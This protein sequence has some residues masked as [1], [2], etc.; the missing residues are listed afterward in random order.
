MMKPKCSSFGM[1]TLA[2]VSSFWAIIATFVWLGLSSDTVMAQNGEPQ[3]TTEFRLEDCKFKTTGANPYFILKP[4]YQLVLE[5]EEDGAMVRLVVTVL[6]KTRR[7]F[8]PGIGKVNTRVVR[9]RHFEDNELVEVSRN[10]FAICEKTND[11][12]YFGE[13][14][15]IFN[16]DGTISNEGAWLAG[17]PDDD[18]LAEPGTFLLGARYFQELADGI[19]MDRA[20]HVEMGLEVKTKAGTFH[21]CVKVLETTPLEPGVESLKTYCPGVGL[22]KDGPVELVEFGFKH[23]DD[24]DDDD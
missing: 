16:P 23:I 18:G 8:L 22:V 19:A 14:V 21:K 7:I 4:R 11:V 15:K 1:R 2:I 17:T 5:G 3:F 10:F 24:D 9:E 6:P 12:F 13:R 20:E